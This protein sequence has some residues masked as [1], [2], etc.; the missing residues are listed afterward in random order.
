MRSSGWKTFGAWALIG[1]LYAFAALG[2]MSIGIF[3]LVF[4]IL[5]TLVAI[6]E[7]RFWPEFLGFPLGPA[8]GTVF[9]AWRIGDWSATWLLATA[10]AIAVA[11]AA[12]FAYV[13]FSRYRGSQMEA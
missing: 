12:V 9:L 2:A 7:L 4:A 10:I 1:G 5:A 13:I 8:A 6:I 11:A 3:I